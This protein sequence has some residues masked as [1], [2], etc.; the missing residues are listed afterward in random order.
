[1]IAMMLFLYK[2]WKIWYSL[3]FMNIINFFILIKILTIIITYTINIINFII[4]YR[5]FYWVWSFMFFINI[6][7]ILWILLFILILLKELINNFL[8]IFS[9]KLLIEIY[10]YRYF[11]FNIFFSQHTII[12]FRYIWSIIC[13]IINRMKGLLSIICTD[14][15]VVL[16]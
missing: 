8:Q 13:W 6:N 1:M 5:I 7:K 14:C 3:S 12:I 15:L 10:L 11:L 4:T 9:T 16:Y 2:L